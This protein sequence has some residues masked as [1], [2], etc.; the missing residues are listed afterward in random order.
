MRSK[1][2]RMWRVI[3]E[4]KRPLLVNL[5]PRV[6]ATA[7]EG[8]VRMFFRACPSEHLI[9]LSCFGFKAKPM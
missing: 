4:G 3:S 6:T 9:C 5:R 1:A 8:R 7:S 2:A